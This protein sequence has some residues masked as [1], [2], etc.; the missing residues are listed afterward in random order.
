M[1]K[2]KKNKQHLLTI[3]ITISVCALVFGA[4]WGIALNTA[5]K[6]KS[7]VSEDKKEVIAEEKKPEVEKV[8]SESPTLTSQDMAYINYMGEYV[9]TFK[10]SMDDLSK[11]LSNLNYSKSETVHVV[12][13]NLLTIDAILIGYWDNVPST[14]EFAESKE[15][16]DTAMKNYKGMVV[17]LQ[18]AIEV[19]DPDEMNS[20]GDFIDNGNKSYKSGL[21]SMEFILSKYTK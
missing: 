2:I 17:L 7:E 4:I 15:M 13:V 21:D 11:N 19:Q 3:F 18:H 12:Q 20:A 14:V 9:D 10:N 16:F 1:A 8:K 5:F 6:D